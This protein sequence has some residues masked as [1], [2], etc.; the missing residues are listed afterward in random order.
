MPRSGR[1]AASINRST[2]LSVRVSVASPDPP[3]GIRPQA[4]CRSLPISEYRR[5]EHR[6]FSEVDQ[7]M[8][9]PFTVPDPRGETRIAR[10]ADSEPRPTPFRRDEPHR[11]DNVGTDPDPFEGGIQ[12]LQLDPPV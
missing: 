10:P 3:G 11:P 1:S 8:A 6:A 9:E 4:T 5:F 7:I 2:P 12:S